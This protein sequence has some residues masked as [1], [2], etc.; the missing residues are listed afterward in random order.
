MGFKDFLGDENAKKILT[1]ELKM[2]KSS[3]TYLFYGKKGVNIFE[4]AINFAK[5]INCPEVENDYCDECR[6]CKSIDKKIYADLKIL[7]M[8]DKSVKVE[9]VREMIIEASNSSYEG[10]AKIFILNKVNKLNKE[11]ANAL[12]KTI[13]EPVKNTY[14]ILLTHN[15]NLL[16]TIISRSSLV[17][18][19][20]LSYK[21]LEVTEE[22]YDFFDGNMEEIL[23]SKNIKE[24]NNN[25]EE[26]LSYEN[27]FDNLKNYIELKNNLKEDLKDIET[28]ESEMKDMSTQKIKFK[29]NIIKCI[30]DY[31]NKKRFLSE[32]E[33]IIFAEKLALEIGKNREFLRDILYIFLLKKQKIEKNIKNLE[34]LLEIKESLNYNVN[35]G[36]V[37]YNFFKNF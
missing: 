8:E 25:F 6:V 29:V 20:P 28:K 1:N 26:E 24:F 10:G 31:I 11:S 21:K 35:V 22:I 19:K 30:I 36:L 5:A 13:E 7:D 23:E 32:L 37:S 14:F 34:K 3:G 33:I 9:Q 2:K 18:I 16:K 15:L 4:F 17:E 12:L 27:I